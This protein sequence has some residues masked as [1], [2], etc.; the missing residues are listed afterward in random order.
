MRSSFIESLAGAALVG[1]AL[2]F[3]APASSAAP[4]P[5]T[6]RDL[7]A[8]AHLCARR[9]RLRARRRR[10]AGDARRRALSRFRR[11]HRGQRARPCPS[12]SRRGADRAGRQALA[13]LEPLPDPGRRAA[14]R[15]GSSTRPS[16]TWSSSP[17]RA[18]RR[19]SARSRWRANITRR[20]ASPS[21]SASSPSKAPSTAAR[22][23]PSRPAASRNTSKASARRS[24]AS[25][26]CPFGDRRGAA[27]PRSARRPAAILIEPIQGEGGVRVVPPEL[28]A[29]A[30]RALRR[31]RPAADLRRGPDRHRPHRQALRA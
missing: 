31:A 16:P 29:R 9:P 25:T 8:A 17:I 30:A 26:R 1:A 6:S 2:S 20:T 3:S 14:G 4:C 21:A 22:S 27:R 24:R 5:E 12:A 28:P 19:S 15:S 7:A 23:R 13:H 10:L 11:R 18:P